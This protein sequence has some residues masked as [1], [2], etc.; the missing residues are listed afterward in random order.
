MSAAR[1]ASN[2]CTTMPNPCAAAST[3]LSCR[4]PV[5][6]SHSTPTPESVGTD[7]MSN[8]RHFALKI[9]KIQEHTGDV[10]ARAREASDKAAGYRIT[11]QVDGDHWNAVRGAGCGLNSGRGG[12]YDGVDSIVDQVRRECRQARNVT[13]GKTD[14]YFKAQVPLVVGDTQALADSRN[15]HIHNR[16][17]T[18]MQQSDFAN[19]RLL[20]P[21]R[22]ERP[23]HRRAAEQRD[24]RAAPHSIT[25]SATNR[26]S[27]L[28]VSPTSLAAFTLMTSSNF[29]GRST[30]KSAGFAPLSILSTYVAVRRNR[31]STFAP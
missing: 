22:R 12:C 2:T 26:M 13:I 19:C 5:V 16:R 20:L 10:T 17:C 23:C 31:S 21:A 7:S 4:A 6:G 9:G 11:F 3:A 1:C 15:A 27:R 30:G 29:V 28:I 18:R 24:E 14:D 25:S 8:C